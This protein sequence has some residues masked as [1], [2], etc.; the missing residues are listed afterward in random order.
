M[1][2]GTF[3]PYGTVMAEIR[4]LRTEKN[5]I[6]VIEDLHW[7]DMA[8][9]KLLN[10]LSRS[11]CDA[12][13]FLLV[14][15]RVEPDGYL[16]RSAEELLLSGLDESAVLEL[17]S[18]IL[19]TAEGSE[20]K[21]FSD[22]LLETTGGNPLLLTELIVHSLETGIVGRNRNESWFLNRR[23]DQILSDNAESFLQARLT[24][25]ETDEK[26]IL[27]IA[28]VLG[29]G[30]EADLLNEICSRLGNK[31]SKIILSRLL[32]LGFLHSYE[33]GSF[34]FLNSLLAEAVYDSILDENRIIMHSLAA[35]VLTERLDPDDTKTGAIT[36]SRHL[37]E[38]E[39]SEN[40]IP[41]LFSALEQ[42]LEAAD[43]NRAEIISTELH[44]RINDNSEHSSLLA[45]SDMRLNMLMGK[46]QLVCN[47]ADK[48]K[49]AFSGDKLAKIY[50]MLASA[51]ENLGVPLRDVLKD[52]MLAIEKAEISGDKNTIANCL[53][54]AGAVNVSL[55]RKN[56]ALSDLNRAL[57]Y[58][59]LLETK[60]LA[61]LHGNM[62]ILMQRTGSLAD[63]FVHYRKTYELGK[64]CGDASIEANALA[65]M[66]QVEI[67]MGDKDAGILKYREALA[68][69]RKS[70][71]IRGECIVLGNLGGTLARFGEA[72]NAIEALER[73]IRIAKEIGHTR[74]I[75]AFH[76]NIGLACKLDGQYRKAEKHLRDALIMIRKTGDKR[77]LAV[78]HLNLSGVLA[79]VMQT[80]EAIDEARR[81]F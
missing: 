53:G 42:C 66:G 57:Q 78:C 30:F 54:A 18:A 51:K 19:G 80:Q 81:A 26:F 77:A 7:A 14:T 5:L 35:E 49:A 32:N 11:L 27:Q 8:S 74:G 9:L 1:R 13:V 62:G 63:A 41:W 76:A 45:Y 70:G 38:S 43:I 69:H 55:G 44:K 17:L 31:S 75:M 22:F 21:V 12:G 40:A 25:L 4:E 24:N 6:L 52:Y 2:K 58:E 71:N 59:D 79:K 65:Y 33:D 73:A 10:Q 47:T 23:F 46:F 20:D 15:S 36:L 37:I 72:E 3:D 61:T 67:N 16:Q 50:A 39:T 29:S 56:E 34:H 68:I 64:K 48:I 60:S 28:S